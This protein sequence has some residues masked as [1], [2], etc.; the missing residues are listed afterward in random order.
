[1]PDVKEQLIR[2]GFDQPKL[3]EHLRPIIDHLSRNDKEGG[4]EETL[5]KEA[6]VFQAPPRLVNDCLSFFQTKYAGHVLALARDEIEK[7][8]KIRAFW[9]SEGLSAPS[10]SKVEDL[11]QVEAKCLSYTSKAREYRTKASTTIP[12]DVRNWS[13]IER[14]NI[15]PKEVQKKLKESALDKIRIIIDFRGKK[16]RGGQWHLPKKELSVEVT[17]FR[18]VHSTGTTVNNLPPDLKNFNIVMD[19]IESVTRHECQHVGQSVLQSI[20]ETR[21]S[22]GYPS[23]STQNRNI[24]EKEHALRDVEFHPRLADE[25]FKFE[26]AT[27]DVKNMGI[28]RLVAKVW[29]DAATP[30]EISRIQDVTGHPYQAA[31]FFSMLKKNEPQK[32]EEAV[33]KFMFEAL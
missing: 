8:N 21:T 10:H 3:Q 16:G 4:H 20:Q 5:E 27:K 17:Q 24:R 19:R 9:E 1:M 6:K 32:W 30:Q 28:K 18:H 11:L 2:L 29:V 26:R 22:P 14:L 12:V 13:Y 15:S 33:K 23:P 31:H 7:R 25:L